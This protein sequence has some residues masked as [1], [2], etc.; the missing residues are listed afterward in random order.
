MVC[1]LSVDSRSIGAVTRN[2][3]LWNFIDTCPY[4]IAEMGTGPTSVGALNLLTQPSNQRFPRSESQRIAPFIV[5][6]GADLVG[7]TFHAEAVAVWLTKQGLHF[8]D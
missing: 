2:P 6:E 7:K 1:F 5:I 4:L 3:K 8:K